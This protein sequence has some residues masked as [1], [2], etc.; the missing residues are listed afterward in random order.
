[1]SVLQTVHAHTIL[2]D[3][4]AD[5]RFAHR[6]TLYVSSI[7]PIFA[8]KLCALQRVHSFQRVHKHA[9]KRKK[10]IHMFARTYIHWQKYACTNEQNTYVNAWRFLC[11]YTCMC[12]HI[13]IYAHFY[14][15]VCIKSYTNTHKIIY[16]QTYVYICVRKHMY[17][18]ATISRLLKIIGLFCGK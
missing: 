16:T 3:G 15:C 6:F 18:V 11:I 5:S 2:P 1:M 7:D 13:C 8:I 10:Y 14:T 4:A 12:I 9:R 17:G